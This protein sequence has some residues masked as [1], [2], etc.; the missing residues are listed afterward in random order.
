MD[1]VCIV[2]CRPLSIDIKKRT[3]S[4]AGR[5]FHEGDCLSLD[6]DSGNVYAG[7][8][9]VVVERPESLLAEVEKWKKGQ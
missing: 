7:A 1:K 9:Q 2:G 6:G 3:C 8:L 5:A 4:I